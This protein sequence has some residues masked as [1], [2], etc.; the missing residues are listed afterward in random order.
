MAKLKK[1][2]AEPNNVMVAYDAWF[3]Y[4]SALPN[5]ADAWLITA[6]SNY[7]VFCARE[8]QNIRQSY[9]LDASTVSPTL[10]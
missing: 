4:S 6:D 1:M 5:L 3:A 10:S 2:Y 8:W 9:F 7:K